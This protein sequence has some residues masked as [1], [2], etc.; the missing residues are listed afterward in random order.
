LRSVLE[1]PTGDHPALAMPEGVSP[2]VRHPSLSESGVM[3]PTLHVTDEQRFDAASEISKSSTVVPTS[4]DSPP[5]RR[6]RLLA[7][8]GIV[9]AVVAGGAILATLLIGGSNGDDTAGGGTATAEAGQPGSG[10][11]TAPANADSAAKPLLAVGQQEPLTGQVTLDWTASGC[12]GVET[13][14]D[15]RSIRAEAS[16][17]VA[18]AF[19]IETPRVL[20]VERC[21]L[22]IAPD[23]NCTC[24]YL[25]TKLAMGDVVRAANTGGSGVAATGASNIYGTMPQQGEWWFDKGVELNGESLVLH[26]DPAGAAD[27]S[28]EVPLLRR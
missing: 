25:E 7:V 16:G 3:P 1:A 8:I 27:Y 14:I 10:S 20:G 17:R 23:A 2:A 15:L 11:A 19:T 22:S 9:A 18:V 4:S 24:I 21:D 26:R 6:G 12:P 13:I 28:Y 5:S